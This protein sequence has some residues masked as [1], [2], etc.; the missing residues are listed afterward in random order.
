MK[1]LPEVPKPPRLV[2][3]EPVEVEE[4]FLKVEDELKF[5]ELLKLFKLLA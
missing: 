2:A 4:S 1:V 3:L 5:L